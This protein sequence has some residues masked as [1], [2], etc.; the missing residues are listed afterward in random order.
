MEKEAF[1]ACW[2]EAPSS[3]EEAS[4]GREASGARLSSQEEDPPWELPSGEAPSP[5]E[6][7][8]CAWQPVRQAQRMIAAMAKSFAFIRILLDWMHKCSRRA[9]AG[10]NAFLRYGIIA[11]SACQEQGKAAKPGPGK[12]AWQPFGP[13]AGKKGQ[14]SQRL[15]KLP[16]EAADKSAGPA[17]AGPALCGCFAGIG[18]ITAGRNLAPAGD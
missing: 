4:P 18:K 10:D 1:S 6:P 9:A 13:A 5:A 15:W 2:A 11:A 14:Y 7:P 12:R 8:H 17:K 3:G 16:G